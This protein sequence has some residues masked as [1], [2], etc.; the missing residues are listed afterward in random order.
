MLVAA[1]RVL[2]ADDLLLLFTMASDGLRS[3]DGDDVDEN[4]D[5]DDGDESGGGVDVEDKDDED[6]I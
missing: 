3:F 6:V 2:A 4:D 1:F 5:D